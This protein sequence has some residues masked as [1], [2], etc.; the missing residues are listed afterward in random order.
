MSAVQK[1]KEEKK[2]I[3][4]GSKTII[5]DVSHVTLMFHEVR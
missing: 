5:R 1:R 3:T 4:E 2:K